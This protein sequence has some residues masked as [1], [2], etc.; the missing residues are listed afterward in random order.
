[1]NTVVLLL[2]RKNLKF[3]LLPLIPTRP[4]SNPTSPCSTPPFASF[5]LPLF[6]G[7]PIFAFSFF[8]HTY[9]RLWPSTS[10]NLI[11][12]TVALLS[13]RAASRSSCLFCTKLFFGPLCFTKNISISH[14][15]KCY[16]METSSP[17]CQSY[18]HRMPL[19]FRYLCSPL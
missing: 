7:L 13:R 12:C 9:L 3:P 5:L 16:Q 14:R 4:T 1:M 18:L 6:L 15:Y 10:L 2:I 19:V 17:S 8:L 11:T